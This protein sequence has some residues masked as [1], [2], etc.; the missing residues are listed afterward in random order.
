MFFADFYCMLNKQNRH[1]VTVVLTRSGSSADQ[2]C[3]IHLP[4][5][6]SNSNPFLYRDVDGHIWVSS[7]VFVDVFVTEDL[8]MR[9]MI[10]RGDAEI[11]DNIPIRGLGKTSQGGQIGIKT[12][13]CEKC[14]MFFVR[15]LAERTDSYE[16]Y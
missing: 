10:G 9:D 15:F 16:V 12:D 8:N 13:D 5:L 2:F 4:R 6:N 7:A 1:H 11:E 3:N 14:D